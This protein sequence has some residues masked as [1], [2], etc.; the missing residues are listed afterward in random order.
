M[1]IDIDDFLEEEIR[2]PANF[3]CTEDNKCI[4][5]GKECRRLCHALNAGYSLLRVKH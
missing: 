3:V 1:G 5:H 2:G 4:F